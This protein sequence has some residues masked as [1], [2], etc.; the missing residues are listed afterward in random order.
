MSALARKH[1]AVNLSQG[2]PDF[3]CSLELQE[4]VAYHLSHGKNQYAPMAGLPALREVIHSKIRNIYNLQVDHNEEITIVAGATQGIFTAIQAFIHIGDEVIIIE[5]A[6][7][8]YRPAVDLVGGITKAYQLS[9]PDYKIDWT[10]IEEMISSRTKMIVVNTPHNPI[11]KVL[12]QEDFK[13]LERITEK[14]D[15]IVL[16]DE[17]YEHLIYD[18]NHHESVLRY[19]NLYKR[20]IAVYSFGKTFHVTGWK[21]GYVV[22]P[23]RLMVE[24]RKV[25]QFNVFCVNSFVQYGIA[26]YMADPS[27][28]LSL[29]NFYQRKR[30]VF[31]DAMKSSKF[32]PL[33]SEGSYFQLYDYSALSDLDDITFSKKLTTEH[34]V[35]VI[36]LSPFRNESS[37]DKVVRFCFAKKEETLLAAADKLSKITTVL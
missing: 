9:H 7:D 33:S 19:P 24:F 30:D 3:D 35:A 36:P 15:L 8:C 5:P 28:Y 34:G 10:E 6:Y 18:G 21:M 37:T 29:P 25:H 27:T 4:R 26:D 14:Y 23:P 11:G 17:V 1:K 22:A 31:T 20:S 13:H 12:S 2:F 16:S 32:K